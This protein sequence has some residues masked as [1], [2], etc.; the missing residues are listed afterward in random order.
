MKT[1]ALEEAAAFLYLS[2]ATLRQKVKSG[3]VKAVKPGRRWVFLEADLVSYLHSLYASSRE[4]PLSGCDKEKPLCHSTNAAIP[5]GYALQRPVESEYATLL[6][7][8]TSKPPRN[9]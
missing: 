2:P 9:T 7:L 6:G 8:P 5:G 1:Y 4:A 3:E